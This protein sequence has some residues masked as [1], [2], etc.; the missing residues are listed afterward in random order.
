MHTPPRLMRLWYL[1]GAGLLMGSFVYFYNGKE[2]KKRKTNFFSTKSQKQQIKKTERDH[3]ERQIESV[4]IMIQSPDE[5]LRKK[6]LEML[7]RSQIGEIR[8]LSG[9]AQIPVPKALLI[10]RGTVRA[11]VEAL[12]EGNESNKHLAVVSLVRLTDEHG[13]NK[14]TNKRENQKERKNE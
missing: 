6:G 7:E 12:K 1:A 9:M 14:Q 4:L 11:L 5:E 8:L 13:K 3:A 10:Q 2:N